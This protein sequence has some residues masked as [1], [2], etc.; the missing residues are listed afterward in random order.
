MHIVIAI[1]G[2]AATAYFWFNRARNARE[3][4]ATVIDAAATARGKMRRAA[5]RRRT[6]VHPA[7]AL[8]EAR[9]AAA[10]YV[11]SVAL[12]TRPWSEE[13][14]KDLL[15]ATVRHLD[16]GGEEAAEV[17]A[18]AHW[19]LDGRDGTEMRRRLAKRLLELAGQEALP[20]TIALLRAVAG[21]PEQ[22]LTDTVA[23][24]EA[25]LRRRFRA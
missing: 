9:D 10:A 25:E 23:D 13:L 18:V 16:C 1:L 21:H 7:D 15:L 11:L 8:T 4:A 22:D 6:E 5:F 24:A 2:A 12:A 14:Q 17:V 20:D 19:T 3:A